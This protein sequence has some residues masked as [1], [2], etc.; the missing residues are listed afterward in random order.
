MNLREIIRLIPPLYRK[1]G[2]GVTL[3]VL[4]QALLNFAGLTL[5]VPLLVLI[6]DPQS[7]HATSWAGKLRME[8]HIGNDTVFTVAV[9]VGVIGLIALKNGLSLLINSFRVKYVNRLFLYFSEKMYSTYFRKGFLFVKQHHTTSFSHKINGICFIFV[10]GIVSRLFVMSG[11]AILLLLIGGALFFYSPFLTFVLIVCLIPAVWIYYLRIRRKISQYGKLENEVW[12]KQMHLI[13]ETFRGYPDL[14][15]N[16]AFPFFAGRFREGLSGIAFYREKLERITSIPAGL[17]ELGVA[18][19]MVLLVLFNRGDA[20]MKVAFGLFAVAAMRMMP[21]IRTLITGWIQLKNNEYVIGTMRE[22][23]DAAG[24]DFSVPGDSLSAP[25]TPLRFK[26]KIEIN[27]LT[28]RFPDAGA[29]EPPVIKNFSLTINKGERIG[30]RGVSGIGK[31]TLLNLLLGLYT[32]QEGSIEIDGIPLES[33][34]LPAWHDLIGYV[35]QDV[36]IMDGTLIENI[37]L[38]KTADEIDRE[39]IR[40]ILKTVCLSDFVASLPEG[41]DTQIGEN[42]C[43]LSGGQR[44]RVGIAR[45]LYKQAEILLFD[46]ATSSIDA[47]T[48][49]E[50]TESI[51]ELSNRHQEL[52]LIL[53]THRESSFTFCDRIVDL[54]LTSN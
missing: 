8:L 4:L 11:E 51:H 19:G 47:A 48:E 36:F 30:I 45:A 39:R 38:G 29:N 23:L 53:I 18:A 15:I 7:I 32:P 1:Q 37:A 33:N 49:K 13:T 42:G 41:V 14:L 27:G 12:R 46:E 35:P 5:L 54:I 44:Q 28:F 24:E 25:Q 31:T 22:A 9:C 43:R 6:L 20:S 40:K 34:R 16:R 50:I 17:T 3:S 10:Q 52:T 26:Q 21:S 2:I